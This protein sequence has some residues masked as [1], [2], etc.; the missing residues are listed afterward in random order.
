MEFKKYQHLERFGNTEVRDIEYGKCYIF[1]KIDGTNGSIWYDEKNGIQAGSRNR[2]L[3]LEN[4]N[5]G[6]YANILQDENIKAYFDKHPNHRLYGEWLVPHSLKT[7]REDAWR[8]FYIFDVCLDKDDTVEY[9]TYDAYQPLLEEFGLEYIPPLA[10]INNPTHDS[11]MK[12]LDKTDQF[13]IK[14][15]SGSGEGIVIKNYNFYNQYGRQTW[16][17]IVCSEFKEKHHKTMGAPEINTRISVEERIVEDFCTNAFIEKEYR[18]II[19]EQ[20]GWSN[21]YIQML[22]GKIF[23]ELTTEEIWNILKKYKNPQINFKTLNSLII[24]KIKMVKN[25]LFK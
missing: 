11:L 13:L 23:Y 18:K 10:I 6:F 24:Q 1:Y 4:D 21:K 3:S 25:E 14:D 17:K 5:A 22:F 16:A 8:K 20:G 19:L 12:C 7:Y 2:T 9:L 15:G